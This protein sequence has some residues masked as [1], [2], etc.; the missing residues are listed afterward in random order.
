MKTIAIPVGMALLFGWWIVELT[1]LGQGTELRVGDKAPDFEIV[2]AGQEKEGSP[3]L[4]LSDFM[5]KKN[6]LVAFFPK[7]F[8]PGCTTQLCGYR[9]D[10]ARF[11]SAE[12]DIVGVSVDPQSEAERFKKE[13]GFPFQVVG[14]PDAKIV[15]AYGVPLVDLPVGHVAKRSAFLIDKTGVIRYID[16]AYDVTAGKDPLYAA[17]KKL[18]DE[19][20]AAK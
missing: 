3:A 9:D 4:K 10:F 13:K 7:A 15:K 19:K 14:D 2:K 11:Q 20:P 16:L 12:T 18:Q 1:A 5:G 17:I 6:V 8:S